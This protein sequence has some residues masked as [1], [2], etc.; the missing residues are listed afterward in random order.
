MLVVQYLLTLLTLIKILLALLSLLSLLT[1]L[2]LLM[3]LIFLFQYCHIYLTF[4]C[5]LTYSAIAN[6]SGTVPIYEG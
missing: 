3:L 5:Y 1:V 6:A 2:S 4:S